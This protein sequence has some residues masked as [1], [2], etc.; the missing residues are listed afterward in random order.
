LSYGRLLVYS[1]I[2]V[3]GLDPETFYYACNARV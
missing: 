1:Y 2:Y 3:T